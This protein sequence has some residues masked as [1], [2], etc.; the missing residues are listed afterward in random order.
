[1]DRIVDL[2]H[3]KFN[4]IHESALLLGVTAL[5][6]QIMGFLIQRILAAKFGTSAELD[7]FYAAF[8]VPDFLY[9]TVAS[10]VA[11]T[12][13]V[14]FVAEVGHL[15]QKK[16]NEFVGAV[17]TSFAILMALVCAVAWVA[18]PWL[19]DKLVPGFAS[20]EKE[21]YIGIARILLLSPFFLGL[22]NLFGALTQS[23]QRFVVFAVGPILYNIGMLVGIL[24]LDDIWHS[25]GLAIGVVIGA[26]M[27]MGIQLPVLAREN[28]FPKFSIALSIASRSILS[29][30]AKVSVLRTVALSSSS[31]ATIVLT[32]LASK[33]NGAVTVFTL[34]SS[35]QGVT[36]TVI[37]MS[38]SVA[39]FPTLSAIWARGDK[40]GFR[41]Q[42]L[43]AS[44]HIVFWSFPIMVLSI[45]L[46]AQIVRVLF[47]SGR[48]DWAA[49]KL[50][51][52]ALALFVISAAAQSLVLL[53][54]RG[55]YAVGD[56]TR[57]LIANVTGAI[58]IVVSAYGL[59]SWFAQN[60]AFKYFLETI[61]RVDGVTGTR[62]L[63][64]PLAY[65]L[66]MIVSFVMLVIELEKKTP[67]LWRGLKRS[68]YQSFSASV[69]MG[70]VAYHVLAILAPELDQNTFIGIFL[71]GLIAGTAAIVAGIFLF[72]IF[73]NREYIEVRRA[74]H[75]R[76]ARKARPILVESDHV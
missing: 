71:Q 32:G 45:V 28:L 38:Y 73:E 48:F 46:R 20:I 31:I 22:S 42:L 35:L 58:V 1:M 6:S 19:A 17:F 55:L 69:L 76:L 37:G 52:A 13:L 14:P 24:W 34:A 62:M 30:I 66:G 49:T 70:F 36:N 50:V 39:A 18:M 12:V 4:G 5:V 26:I 72:S 29:R 75:S 25:W 15:G 56:T 2:M 57:A 41:G 53:F 11:V 65:S 60:G 23:L 7:V 44:R 8:R 10:F 43:N 9:A 51:A 68:F 16:L 63:A 27:H 61:L 54:T 64:L 47:G 21:H 40:A 67:H 33:T 3:R 74:L 59:D